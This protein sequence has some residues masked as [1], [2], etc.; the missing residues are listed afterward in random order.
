MKAHTNRPRASWFRKCCALGLSI[1]LAAASLTACS[2]ST[3]TAT[4]APP[5]TGADPG[6]ANARAAVSMYEQVPTGFDLPTLSSKAPAGKTIVFLNA[7]AIQTNQVADGIKAAAAAV[8]WHYRQI[9]VDQSDPSNVV[10]G[11][12]QALQYSPY[13]V[14]TTGSPYSQWSSVLPAY[15]KAGA[16]IIPSDAGPPTSSTVPTAIAGNSFFSTP[17]T[18]LA[19]WVNADSDGSGQ[20]LFVGTSAIAGLQVLGNTFEANI[21]QNCPGCKVTSV[22]LDLAQALG[23]QGNSLV[24]TALQRDPAIKYVVEDDGAF[25]TGL[26]SSLAAAGLA[27]KVKIGSG[28]GA[29]PNLSAVKSGTETVTT[30]NSAIIAGWL[31]VDAA[32]RHLEGMSYPAGYGNPPTQLLTK[33]NNWTLGSSYTQPANY[34]SLFEQLWKVG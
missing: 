27:G 26:S 25:F 24:V 32:L 3:K 6:V 11:F 20:V 15:Q 12:N 4:T 18:M 21:R 10:A 8:G 7:G 16:I 17:G 9:I 29:A 19:D 22:N 30:G 1:P 31:T 33:T 23:N 2:S 13:V 34:V 28:F 14:S 5:A